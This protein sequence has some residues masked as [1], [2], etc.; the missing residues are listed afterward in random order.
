M[1]LR[2]LRISSQNLQ[3]SFTGEGR[4]SSSYEMRSIT[5]LFFLFCFLAPSALAQLRTGFYS[6]SCPR[7][8]SIVASVVA[9]RFRSDKSITAAFL[10]MQFHDCFVRVRKL[11][12]CVHV[13]IY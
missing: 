1:H 5:A 7:A 11:L 3:V 10:R 6:R 9:N 8:E 2:G 13:Y 4:E 12:L